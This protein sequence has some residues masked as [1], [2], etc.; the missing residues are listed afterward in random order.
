MDSE[1]RPKTRH[2]TSNVNN[3]EDGSSMSDSDDK[4]G[5]VLPLELLGLIMDVLASSGQKKTLLELMLA[6]HAMFHLGLVY[7]FRDVAVNRRNALRVHE[8]LKKWNAFCHVRLL[9]VSRPFDLAPAGR[10]SQTPFVSLWLSCLPY[11]RRL[12]IKTFVALGLGFIISDMARAEHLESLSIRSD[13]DDTESSYGLR[14]LH[15]VMEHRENELAAD[16]KL[17]LPSSVKHV[18]FEFDT[19]LSGG[20]TVP[21]IE[22]I[23]ALLRD[24]SP[25]LET[26]TLKVDYPVA[27]F[28]DP[29]KTGTKLLPKP[30]AAKPAVWTAAN[31]LLKKL[32]KVE[33]LDQEEVE[34]LVKRA[35]EES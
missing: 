27:R 12:E 16:K 22:A 23:I 20:H 28:L 30:G 32:V 2:S 7:F 21:F 11:I 4:E 8:S 1:T 14:L 29:N 18:D 24:R 17:V 5:P 6:S 10:N 3:M 15:S 19:F 31:N 26:W 35:L 25:G 13:F 34:K 33:V 9:S